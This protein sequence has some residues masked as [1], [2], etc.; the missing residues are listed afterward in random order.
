M[1][2]CVTTT[3]P[4]TQIFLWTV[5]EK[6]EMRLWCAVN[7]IAITLSQQQCH[8]ALDP[9]WI[10]S[11]K[12]SLFSGI[13]REVV[14]LAGNSVLHLRQGRAECGE[15]DDFISSQVGPEF[16]AVSGYQRRTVLAGIDDILMR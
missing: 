1:L 10:G 3:A 4:M 6:G 16:P 5:I 13:S 2:L 9:L 15:I 8:Q 7:E 12:V 14:E 11:G